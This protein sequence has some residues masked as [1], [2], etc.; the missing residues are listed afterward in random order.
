MTA[1]ARS[2]IKPNPRLSGSLTTSRLFSS[3]IVKSYTQTVC[4]ESMGQHV[5]QSSGTSQDVVWWIEAGASRCD[6]DE[7]QEPQQAQCWE[8]I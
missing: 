1:K 4:L 3:D 6:Q 5:Q 7:E 2:H 8:S